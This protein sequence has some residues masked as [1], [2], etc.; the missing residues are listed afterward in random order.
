MIFKGKKLQIY[1]LLYSDAE[2]YRIIVKIL[3]F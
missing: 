3:D 2:P 1:K